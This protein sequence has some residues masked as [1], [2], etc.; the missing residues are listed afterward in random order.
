[1]GDD[2]DG[3]DDQENYIREEYGDN[4]RHDW[5]LPIFHALSKKE[6]DS[7]SFEERRLME[8]VIKM[9]TTNE[10]AYRMQLSGVN[11]SS[12]LQMVLT[13]S[14]MELFEERKKI[15]KKLQNPPNQP[16]TAAIHQTGNC[17]SCCAEFGKVGPV[18]DH[19]R[20]GDELSEYGNHLY[21]YRRRVGIMN[22]VHS[23]ASASTSGHGANDLLGEEMILNAVE[24]YQVD[25]LV[26]QLNRLLYKYLID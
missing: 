14:T 2:Q 7:D 1:M 22:M 25:G 19:C 9:V 24:R 4:V 12:G 6:S 11:V 5:W 17:K 15:M 8:A 18:C 13:R 26:L 10:N 21:C 3:D 23:R 20:I 16:T